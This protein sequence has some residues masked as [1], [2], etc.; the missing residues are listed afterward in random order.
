MVTKSKCAGQTIDVGSCTTGLPNSYELLNALRKAG[1]EDQADMFA[2]RA[3]DCAALNDPFGVAQLLRVLRKHALVDVLVARDPATHAALDNPLGVAALIQ[4]LREV[5]AKEQSTTLADRAAAHAA[6]DPHDVTVPQDERMTTQ[7][8]SQ[9][10][11]VSHLHQAW[12][13][14]EPDGRPAQPWGWEDLR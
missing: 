9:G 5:G 2:E 4:M 10:M 1:A 6:L 13:G 7:S 12:F 3:S 14:H 8:G 11:P